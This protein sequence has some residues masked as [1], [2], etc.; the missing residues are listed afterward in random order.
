[1]PAGL[2][3][4][5]GPGL[6]CLAKPGLETV[7]QHRT[8]PSHNYKNPPIGSKS[9]NLGYQVTVA[10]DATRTFDITT[11]LL[12]GE[13]TLDAEH[14]MR[15]TAINLHAGGFATIAATAD[16]IDTA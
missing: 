9:H 12:D 13:V 10:L 15:A 8:T 11:A 7:R 4:D 3:C 5:G 1:M 2:R 16:V 14:L 6:A